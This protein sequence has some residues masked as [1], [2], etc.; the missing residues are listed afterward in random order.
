[1]HLM[2]LQQ[3]EEEEE[4]EELS[5]VPHD[6]TYTWEHITAHHRILQWLPESKATVPFIT[7]DT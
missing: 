2:D 5:F 1:M 6:C 7:F 4:K 3:E